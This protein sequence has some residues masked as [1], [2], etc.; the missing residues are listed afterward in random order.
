MPTILIV[1]DDRLLGKLLKSSLEKGGFTVRWAKTGDEGFKEL[2][3]GDINLIYLDIMLPGD[4][5]GYAILT[6]LKAADSSYQKIPVIMIS[7]LSQANEINRAISLGAVDFIV[8]ANVNLEDIV[9]Q[10]RTRLG[11]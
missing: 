10:T 2:A 8:K 7:N 4:L 3:S 5:D 1:E 6:R 11:I 9:Q